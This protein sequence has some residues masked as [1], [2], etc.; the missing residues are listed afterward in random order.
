M[1]YNVS[2]L[3]REPVGST[4][5]YTID[6]TITLPYEGS[7]Q[8]RVTGPLTLI[9][10]P[11]GLLARAT[12]A[13]AARMM[14]GRCLAPAATP[15]RLRIEEEYLPRIDPLTGARLAEPEE[16]TPF[17]IDEHHHL[18]LEEAVRQAAV[19]EEPMA[20]LCRSECRGLCPQCGADLNVNPCACNTVR[21][22]ER[23]AALERVLSDDR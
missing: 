4:R 15:L 2:Q 10:T 18:D 11:R 6:Q 1:F 16:P 12:L 8:A 3:L 13:A 17:R 9:R 23:W 21:L 5:G 22:D 19:L 7:P 14:C 20:P